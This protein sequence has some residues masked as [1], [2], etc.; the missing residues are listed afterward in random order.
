MRTW[1]TLRLS[2]SIIVPCNMKLFLIL[3]YKVVLSRTYTHFLSHTNVSILP[4]EDY[5]T[6]KKQLCTLER[7]L[8]QSL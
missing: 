6:Q 3:Y 4:D 7:V 5:F 8:V 2:H 1:I